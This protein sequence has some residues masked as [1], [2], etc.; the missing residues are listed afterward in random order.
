V[1]NH[2]HNVLEKLQ[3]NRRAEAAAYMRGERMN[4][5]AGLG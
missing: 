2:V 1:K 3:V 5:G 4:G